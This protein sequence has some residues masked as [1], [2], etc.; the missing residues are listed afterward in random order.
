MKNLISLLIAFL[1][2]SATDHYAS[3]P[4]K[5]QDLAI[6]FAVDQYQHSNLADLQNPVKNATDIAGVLHSARV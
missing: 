4:R 2:L 1:L 3:L 5:G 6:F